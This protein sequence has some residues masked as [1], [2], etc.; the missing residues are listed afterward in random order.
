MA[1]NLT[2]RVIVITGASSGIGAATAVACARAGM[3]V[4]L[5][6]RREDRLCKVAELVRSYGTRA[7]VV[8]CDVQRDGDVS[9]LIKSTMCEWGRLD[10]LFAN[11]GYGLFSK[12]A[13]TSPALIRDIFETNFWGTVRCIQ[14]V[15]PV[16]R[17]KGGGHLLICASAVSEIGLP[18]Y[19]YYAATKAAQDAIAGAMRAE[20]AEE[21]I[22]VS[23]VHPIGTETEFF[24]V[25]RQISPD[26]HGD[27]CFNTPSRLTHTAEKV[28]RSVVNCLR[29]PRP[30][31]WP[32]A[33]A[34]LGLAMT[35]AVPCLS[36]WSMNNLLHR[37]YEKR[38]T[39]GIA[40]SSDQ[41]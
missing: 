34:R 20:L 19:G 11:A 7:R 4:A 31:V 22:L 36:A 25:V 32:S 14:E 21:H 12:V 1:K 41:G 18:M 8:P 29:R 16:M 38:K 13:D 33:P 10:A 24:D 26:A 15:V 27:E 6:A 9:N 39:H 5:A 23:S 17:G 28:A 37:R 2:G 40:V 35:T 30:E 3:D